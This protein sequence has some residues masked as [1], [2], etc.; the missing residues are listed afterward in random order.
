MKVVKNWQRY[1]LEWGILAALIVFALVSNVIGE[2]I[3][4]DT[5]CP[6][7]GIQAFANLI[8]HGS[9]PC[10]M[11]S[12]Q[13]LSGI[14]L[15]AAVVLFSKLFCAYLCPLGTISDLCRKLRDF[16]ELK[17]LTIQS[18]S[19]WDKVLRIIKYLL[20]FVILYGT[21]TTGELVCKKFDPYYALATGFKGELVLWMSVSMVLLLV[22]GSFFIDNFWCKYICPLGAISNTFKYWLWMITVL[23]ASYAIF[24]VTKSPPVWCVVAMIC[25]FGYLLEIFNPRT[26]LQVLYV[27]RDKERC[28]ECHVCDIKCP[29][30]INVAGFDGAVENVDC[31]LCGECVA[32]CPSKALGI[33]IT[34]GHNLGKINDFI[35]AI[36]TVVLFASAIL[37]GRNSEIPT[38]NETWNVENTDGLQTFSMGGL[39]QVR[40]YASC[41]AFVDKLQ[42]VEGVYGVKTYVKHHKA[43]ILYN[44]YE[45]TQEKIQESLFVSAKFQISTPDY[46]TTPELVVKTIRAE[47]MTNS[48]AI[49][50]LGLQFKKLDSL[51]YGLKIDWDIPLIVR[52]YVDPAF[53]R[54]EHW[55]KNVVELPFLELKNPQNGKIT[56]MPLGF[57]FVRMEQPDSTM[58][59]VDFLCEMFK[60]FMAEFKPISEVDSRIE[61]FLYEIPEE[62][63]TKP[64][65][66]RNLPLL[67]S[68]LDEL[69]RLMS[70]AEWRIQDNEGEQSIHAPF[71][72]IEKGTVKKLGN[73]I[74][75]YTN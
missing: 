24:I 22:L 55:I 45:T 20:L 34:K 75:D 51:I 43:T 28:N 50:L 39:S 9:L 49:N 12:L 66:M 25:A 59:T 1:V 42:K 52:M 40:C 33:G 37:V 18:Y 16:F 10:D 26:S 62:N 44:P 27:Q 6:F 69:F 72:Y 60:P 38:I 47:N 14:A 11:S 74:E 56:Q 21:I 68:Y 35:P 31:M 15:I 71:R 4:P 58:R 46:I 8:S 73:S 61:Q 57:K 3:N 70:S 5:Y 30:H 41:R 48:N 23:G 7:G 19:I 54:D 63:I 65:I 36:L 2:R 53:N 13:I 64:V 67:A 32:N 29:Y 17:P